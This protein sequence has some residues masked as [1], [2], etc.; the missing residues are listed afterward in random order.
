VAAVAGLLGREAAALTEGDA[1]KLPTGGASAAV[2]ALAA[3]AERLEGGRVLAVEQATAVLVELAAGPL[4]VSRNESPAQPVP[5]GRLTPG[6]DISISLAAYERA[7]EAKLHLEAARCRACGTLS[8]PPRYRC[9]VCGSEESTEV[10]ALPREAEVY[11][12]VTIHVPVPGLVTPY[13]LALVELGDTEVRVLVRLTGA[14]PGAVAI[15]DRGS[16][17]F[18]RVAVRSGVPDYGYAFLP[19]TRVE[20]AA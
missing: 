19:T 3:V 20:V 7:F 13:S 15:G 16:M 2:F 11:S 18:R 1:P 4:Q 17:V 9:L 12:A 14:P 5:P 8:Y 6:G 10:F